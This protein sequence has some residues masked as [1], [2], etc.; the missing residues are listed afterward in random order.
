MLTK[1]GMSQECGSDSSLEKYH[2][3]RRIWDTGWEERGTAVI[4]SLLP[5][6]SPENT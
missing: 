4:M 6:K 1:P 3:Q 2:N 5:K